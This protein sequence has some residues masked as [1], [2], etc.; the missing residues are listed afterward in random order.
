[1]PFDVVRRLGP[2]NHISVP[3]GKYGRTIVL[4]GYEWICDATSGG[5]AACSRITLSNV[6]IIG[7]QW[8]QGPR[9]LPAI[10]DMLYGNNTNR[11]RQLYKNISM[12]F[13]F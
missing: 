4:G 13:L 6:V 10:C 11:A 7:S 12:L 8:V 1:M 5:D 2:T 3:S 9:R